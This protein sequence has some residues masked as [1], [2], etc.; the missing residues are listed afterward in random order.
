MGKLTAYTISILGIVLWL[1]CVAV[2]VYPHNVSTA[3]GIAVAILL[4]P[5]C[6]MI[7]NGMCLIHSYRHPRSGQENK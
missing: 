7:A 6:L 3:L 1:F 2:G 5:S 4:F